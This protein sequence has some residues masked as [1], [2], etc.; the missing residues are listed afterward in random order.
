MKFGESVLKAR[1]YTN[2]RRETGVTAG[3]SENPP[4]MAELVAKYARTVRSQTDQAIRAAAG[5]L[6]HGCAS[7]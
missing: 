3:A 4:D 7:E 6:S 2:G 1:Q 5:A